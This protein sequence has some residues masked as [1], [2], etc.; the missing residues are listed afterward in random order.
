MVT[1]SR[2]GQTVRNMKVSGNKTRLMATVN[3]FMLM[4]MFTRASGRMTKHTAMEDTSMLMEQLML[5]IGKTISSMERVLKHG[6]TGP[7]MKDNT[8]KERSMAREHLPL[9][10]AAFTM[11]TSNRMR[12]QVKADTCGPMAKLMKG[13]GRKTRCM[14]TEF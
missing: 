2:F 13:I 4:V 7:N 11:E 10:M 9:Q 14:D 8:S 3:L 1:G 12:S 5:E 6:L